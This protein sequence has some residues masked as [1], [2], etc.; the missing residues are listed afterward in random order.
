MKKI[1][2]VC[3]FSTIGEKLILRIMPLTSSSYRTGVNR[4]RVSTIFAH[5]LTLTLVMGDVE[6]EYNSPKLT[7]KKISSTDSCNKHI[8][9]TC[10]ILLLYKNHVFTS[11]TPTHVVRLAAVTD[12]GSCS[13]YNHYT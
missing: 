12:S 8:K 2:H 3:Y 5:I 13:F 6:G 7:A 1:R 4:P 11:L 10:K 9:R